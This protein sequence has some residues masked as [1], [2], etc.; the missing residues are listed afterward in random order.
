[1][2]RRARDY[3]GPE[4]GEF[5]G[6]RDDPGPEFGIINSMGIGLDDDDFLDGLCVAEPLLQQFVG[7]R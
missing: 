3:I 7:A 4:R 6:K 1:M 2:F 5:T